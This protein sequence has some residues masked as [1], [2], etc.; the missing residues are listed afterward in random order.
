MARL[1]LYIY[2]VLI[3]IIITSTFSCS[4][5]Q[6]NYPEGA[7][8]DFAT[9]KNEFKQPSRDYG[10][11]P[12]FV[13]NSKITRKEIDEKMKDF[14]DAGCGSVIVHP[15]PG[16]ITEYLSDKWFDLFRYTVDKGK[17]LD[18]NVWIYDENSYPSGFAGGHVPAQM[19][20]SYN[21]GQ[22]LQ[23][24]DTNMIPR[25]YED[26]YLILQKENGKYTDI[27]NIADKKY[28]KKGDYTIFSKT[29]YRKSDWYGGFSY[30]D[31][32]YPGVTQ[33]FIEITM[34]GYEKVAGDEFGEIVSGV[35][36]DEPYIESS[37][38]I[39]WTPDLFDVFKNRW[40]YDLKLNLPSLY[41]EV[42]DWKRIRHNYTQTL[43]QLFIDRWAKPTYEYCSK[44]GLIST[45]HYWEHSW[46]S[47]QKG[48]DNMAMY[49][50][51][52]VPGIDMLFNQ[53][54]EESPSAQ[55][56]NI[57]AVKE[58]A[59]VA[60]QLGWHRTLSETYGGG[61]WELTFKD[62]KR[63]G[64]WEYVLG[65][66]LMNQHLSLFTLAG[67]RKYDYPPSFSYHTPWWKSYKYLNNYYARLSLALSSGKQKNDILIIE[68]TTTAWLYD[69]Y[70]RDS[71]NKQLSIIGKTFQKFVTKLEK[72]QTEY[73]LGSE[74]II[75]NHGFIDK[76]R[77]IVGQCSYSKV[78]IPPLT[79]TLNKS[80]FQLLK[81]FAAN[82]GKIISF[83][84]PTL[85]DGGQSRE[86]IDF[87]QQ[88][89]IIHLQELTG[90]VL[91]GHFQTPD[92]KIEN[93][94]G[95]DLYH[96]RRRIENGQIIFLA[97]SSMI[98]TSSGSLTINGKDAV[99]LN[100]FSGEIVDYNEVAEGKNIRLSF[101][102]PPAESLLLYISGT[103][104]NGYKLPVD[105][106]KLIPVAVKSDIIVKREEENVLTIDFCD[107]QITG[108]TE[109]DM[110]VYDATQKVFT[111]NGF[112]NGN[113]WNHAV[114]Y[115]TSILDR[116]DFANNSGFTATYRFYIDGEFDFSK[117]K[118][119]VERPQ[120]W[121]VSIN[122]HDVIPETG[123]WWLDR[124][125]GVF[126][127][128][129]WIK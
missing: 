9:L 15:R 26:Y 94:K 63:L 25:D 105:T 65:V 4:Y 18:M 69:S 42:G 12:F 13:W 49:A 35:F 2:S 92:L 30:V 29:F 83:S 81:Q 52:Q 28:G 70:I 57:R 110:H 67:A 122:G 115:K 74:D 106:D 66:N 17:E 62:M 56:G 87:F 125:F 76:A 50:Y 44:E 11:V 33:K 68:P 91:S 88:N 124:S 36:T 27:T 75:K 129:K 22:G 71:C 31:L 5:Q 104:L 61:G 119:V 37:G 80:T 98:S 128:D 102:L 93:V 117:I 127:I 96:H 47:M 14:K 55:F 23:P 77:L 59:S 54:N 32:L 24:L 78:V 90:K 48:G 19:P 43:L 126:P 34:T 118:T 111:E 97:N 89:N 82:G 46:P 40:G 121:T 84:S 64:D 99:L 1:I 7:I 72:N 109:K 86:V 116:A 21:Q 114:Q 95:G 73:D 38:G 8:T 112:K 53:F 79:E 85:I 39:R 20:E 123:K 16:L 113:P 45:G 100:A 10:T 41:K 6:E 60:N 101:S 120:L 51:K 108:K 58:L 107:L 3:G 103:R